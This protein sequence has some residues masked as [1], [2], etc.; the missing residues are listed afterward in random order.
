MLSTTK[1]NNCYSNIIIVYSC[2]R[3][4]Q[5]LIKTKYCY[6]IIMTRFVIMTK[7]YK[8]IPII[9][10]STHCLRSKHIL[11]YLAYF[12]HLRLNKARTKRSEQ[13]QERILNIW[14]VENHRYAVGCAPH[15]SASDTHVTSKEQLIGLEGYVEACNWINQ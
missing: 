14:G 10:S 8:I 5:V 9:E 6:I 11:W 15:R 4:M 13:K 12:D 3:K 1:S 7:F 2:I